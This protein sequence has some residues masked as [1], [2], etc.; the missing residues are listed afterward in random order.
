MKT[1]FTFGQI[2]EQRLVD[3][4]WTKTDLARRLNV[5]PSRI[6]NLLRQPSITENVFRKCLYV[7][8]MTISI[9]EV[10]R[11]SPPTELRPQKKEN[12]RMSIEVPA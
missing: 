8:G 3:L 11:P 4:G 10:E 7:L 9:Q 1:P 5:S 12:N 6:N 2:I